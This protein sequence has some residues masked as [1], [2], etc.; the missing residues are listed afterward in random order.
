MKKRFEEY[1]REL[2]L[3]LGT[4]RVARMTQKD[5]DIVT[6]EFLG[7]STDVEVGNYVYE[8][9][10]VDLESHVEVDVNKTPKVEYD[11]HFG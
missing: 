4:W 10:T 1:L 7:D 3:E 6:K 5:F 9:M 11:C 2:G 8:F